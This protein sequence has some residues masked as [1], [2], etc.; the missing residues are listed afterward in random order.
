MIR[1]I[2]DHGKAYDSLAFICPGCFEMMDGAGLHIWRSYLEEQTSRYRGV[3]NTTASSVPV[4]PCITQ[5]VLCG[6]IRVS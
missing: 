6:T 4:F 5:K 3:V 1:H 2:D